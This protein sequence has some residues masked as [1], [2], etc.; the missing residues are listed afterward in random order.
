MSP[1]TDLCPH[2]GSPDIRQLRGPITRT[3]CCGGCGWCGHP[4][5]L[6]TAQE[7]AH[8]NTSRHCP[9]CASD[10]VETSFQ[11]HPKV[12]N[13]VCRVCGWTGFERELRYEEDLSLEARCRREDREGVAS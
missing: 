6:V 5:R 13:T 4:D 9:D 12:P 7:F 8:P 11:D 1:R 3:V 10:D 2:C